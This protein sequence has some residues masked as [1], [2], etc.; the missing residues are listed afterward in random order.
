MLKRSVAERHD[1]IGVFFHH[2]RADNFLAD[3]D[4]MC[5]RQ[6]H[7]TALRPGA[8]AQAGCAVERAFEF[9]SAEDHV[10][11]NEF[12]VGLRVWREHAF[13]QRLQRNVHHLFQRAEAGG[14][15]AVFLFV[16]EVARSRHQLQFGIDHPDAQPGTRETG[17]DD[18]N[19]IA[20]F[21]RGWCEL[22]WCG[23][24]RQGFRWFQFASVFGFSWRGYF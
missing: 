13:K 19:F 23:W 2:H 12:F 16:I 8:A 18:A 24:R 1:G 11:G 4:R 6:N 20:D 22:R 21:G 9:A 14:A 5:R 15:A 7:V 10:V 3:P 17:D